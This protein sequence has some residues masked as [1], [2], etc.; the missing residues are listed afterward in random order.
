MGIN[1]YKGYIK[2]YPRYN[3]SYKYFKE[4][5]IKNHPGSYY[6]ISKMYYDKLIGT[7]SNEELKEAYNYLIK[8]VELNNIPG[9]NLLGLL[10]LFLLDICRL[11]IN[12][13]IEY[14]KIASSNNYAYAYNNLGKIYENKKDYKKAFNY[15][16]KSSLLGESWALN[17]LGEY[18]RLGI[19]VEKDI[20][21]AFDYYNE[22]IDSPIESTCFHAYYNLAKY[23]YLANNTIKE[24]N[25]NTAIE[26]SFVVDT[27]I[28]RKSSLL[29]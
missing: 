5:S 25:I 1:E 21:K 26:Y 11:D 10:Y 20:Q 3:I 28:L 18:Y 22:A 19:C 14:F 23:F 29:V 8:A 17:K 15:Y 12:K 24:K 2:G 7:H 16:Q 4:A 6:M 9:I 27:M 13:A